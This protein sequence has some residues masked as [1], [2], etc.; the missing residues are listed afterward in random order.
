MRNT[1]LISPRL[2]LLPLVCFLLLFGVQVWSLG[3]P[4]YV[5]ET[6]VTDALPLVEGRQVAT[7]YVDDEDHK[8]VRRA[9][10]DLQLDIKRVT[11][12]KARRVS[13]REDLGPYAV[14]VGTL[15]LSPLIDELVNKKIVDPS[16]IKGKWD[17]FHLEVVD[18]PLEG[19][20]RA[21]VIVGADRRGTTYG[22]YDVSQQ[23]GVSPWYYWA[24]VPVAKKK[25]IY[26]LGETRVQQAPAVKYRGIFLNDEAPALTSWVQEN[27]GNY[28]HEFYVKVFE[29]LLRLK[30]NFMWPA[31]WNNAFADD[32]PMNM[33]LADEYGIVMSTSHHEPMMRADKEWNRHGVGKWEYSTNPENLYDFWVDGAKRNKNYESIYTMGMRGQEDKPMSEGENIELLE[34]IVRDQREILTKVFTDRDITD[35]PQVWCLYKE[36]QAYY[37]KGMRVPDDVILL[38]SDDNW[39]NIRRLPSPQE[40]NR[41]G[42]AGVYY[43]F[44]YVGGPRSYRWINTVPLAKIWEQMHLAWQYDATQIWITNVGDLKPMEFPIEFFLSMAWNPERW[45]KD[46]I[47]EFGR[48]WAEREFGK[49]YAEEIEALI[50]GYTRHNGRRKPEQQAPG[51]Y[52]VLNYNEAERVE[53]ELNDLVARAEKVYKELPRNKRD[54]FFQLVLHP[55]KAS[56]IVTRMYNALERNRL[57]AHQ[58]RAMANQFAVQAEQ[59]FAE[60]AALKAQYHKLNGGKWKGFMN[61]S[62]IGYR[63]WNNPEADQ[64]PMTYNY[65]PG[66]YAEFGVAVEGVEPA[67]PEGGDYHL[68]F[69][70]AGMQTRWLEIFNRGTQAFNFSVKPREEW[71]QVSATEGPVNDQVRVDVSIDWSK[72][73][74]GESTGSIGVR[75]TGWAGSTVRVTAFKPPQN[76]LKMAKGFLEADGYISIEAANY[77]K[78][79]AVNGIAWQEIPLHGRTESSISTYPTGDTVFD[80]AGSGPW[81]EYPLTFTRAGEVEVQLFLAPTWPLMP[82]RSLRYGVSLGGDTI[83]LVDPLVDFDDTRGDWGKTVSDGVRV[84]SSVHTVKEAGA[85]TLRIYMVDPA[86]TIQKIVIDTGGLK[87][88]YLGPLESTYK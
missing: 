52:S 69:D 86:V 50:T 36:V 18:N 87:E 22:I 4:V 73:P 23:I 40:R 34:T 42:G 31:M 41:K 43:H 13:R 78:N 28:T 72:L 83:E 63:S 48:L 35:V 1:P 3:D 57:Y 20:E 55:V 70:Q 32:D 62:H 71:I 6:V 7:L 9:L 2:L 14:I 79:Q 45:G 16:A 51:T 44:D 75:G 64:M 82:G 5:S 56:A 15:G 24:D 88:S 54:A 26:I 8:G 10:G 25:N 11:G 61:Q 84:S 12:K 30:A 60:D 81:I 53:A 67:W 76:V 80:K 65:T 27:H 47:Q 74:E 68:R 38:W 29:L 39:G 49:E 66:D 33:I 37:E 85:N 77:K 21:L 19:V 58:G 17:A 59:L 46:N